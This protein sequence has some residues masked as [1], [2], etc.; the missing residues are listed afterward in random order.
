MRRRGFTMIELLTA[1]AVVVLLLS[2]LLPAVQR[3]RD[4]ARKNLCRQHL[5]VLGLALHN[6]H[7]V[8]MMFAPGWFT[9]RPEGAG[10][11]ATGWQVSILPYIGNGLKN[12]DWSSIESFDSELHQSL[13]S[14]HGVYEP[15]SG[16]TSLLKTS[17]S[18]YRCPVDA[19]DATNPFRGG[20]GTSNYSG[21]YGSIPVP[22]W[23]QTDFWPGQV[24]ARTDFQRLG[25]NE[26]TQPVVP[27]GM[28]VVNRGVRIRDV[29]DGTSNTLLVGERGVFSQGGIWPGPRSNFHENDV[30]TDASQFTRLNLS[31]TG[32][33][34]RHPG[35]VNFLT[36]DGAAH[37]IS[38]GIDSSHGTALLQRLAARNDGNPIHSGEF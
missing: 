5:K 21:N 1:S 29:T 16:D 22:R 31:V 13:E 2:T 7:D 32:F 6:Y 8:Y 35:I 23:A 20:W 28:F 17:I 15:A 37:S 38:D 25:A 10:H 19:M 18:L 36:A 33:S 4:D 34:S 24:A 27:N 3:A 30:V 26:G 14:V 12:H 11:A 9:R